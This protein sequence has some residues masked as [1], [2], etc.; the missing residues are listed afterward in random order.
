MPIHHPEVRQGAAELET[1]ATPDLDRA[2]A[3]PQRA[4]ASPKVDVTALARAFAT[5]SHA[6]GCACCGANAAVQVAEATPE[7]HV[8][9]QSRSSIHG[10]KCS[11]GA[12][13]G[14]GAATEL[15]DAQADTTRA[16]TAKADTAEAGL[17]DEADAGLDED[18]RAGGCPGPT[19]NEAS[20]EQAIKDK[21]QK[22]KDAEQ[23]AGG[24]PGP[25][26]SEAAQPAAT[27]ASGSA[28]VARAKA[29]G[30][31]RR[32]IA[33]AVG[34]HVRQAQSAHQQARAGWY[35]GMA[36]MIA[37]AGTVSAAYPDTADWPSTLG[38]TR[39][40]YGQFTYPALNFTPIT[41]SMPDGVAG[42]PQAFAVELQATSAADSTWYC[43]AA[44]TGEKKWKDITV[45]VE[46]G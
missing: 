5:S 22:A 13:G 2:V 16:D 6:A 42:P 31:A 12:C 7:A 4:A 8:E 39:W 40:N 46:G 29:P 36:E 27:P 32:T 20:I 44:P 24:E 28:K 41:P 15:R 23:P 21:V 26:G 34:Q 37:G 33:K 25:E 18:G 45:P 35:Q 30:T 3:R 38:L 11:C 19:L 9:P 1:R 14:G 17:S 43:V 10:A